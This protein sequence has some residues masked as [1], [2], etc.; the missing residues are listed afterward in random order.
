[1]Q[2]SANGIA[3][4]VDDQGPPA[5]PAVLLIMGLG[6][7]LTA[8]PD[9]LVNDLLRR[10]F[11][12]IRFDNRDVGLSQG[13]DDLG[14][15]N[16]L[17]AGLKHLVHLP[18]HS[19]YGLADM[20]K[21]AVG[22]LDALGVQRA[23]VVG[24]SLGGMVAQHVAANHAS[25]VLSLTL[26]MTTSS[27]RALPQPA[28]EVSRKLMARPS[29]TSPQGLAEHYQQLFETIGSPAYRPDP[30]AFHEQM[31]SSVQ[32][33]WRPLGTARQLAAVVADGDRTA[34][35][36]R[37]QAPTHIVHGAD[38]PLIPVAAARQL[39]QCITGATVDIIA[40]MGHD[41]PLPLMP[42]LAAG[43]AENAA[44]AAT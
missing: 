39:Q 23:H 9:V 1:M 15:P 26:I 35:L 13:F 24:A 37:I 6:M 44:R 40:G 36:A 17:W 11:R 29:D 42:R 10:G 18:V 31:M 41:F 7:Q 43:I 20:A 21:D 28:L 25:R 32:R 27:A 22:V 8:W 16:L 3:I 30:Q 12:V 38:D 5:A 14:S 2:I 4:E 33:A 19:P 34:M